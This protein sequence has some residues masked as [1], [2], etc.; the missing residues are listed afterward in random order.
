MKTYELTFYGWSGTWS[1]DI[2][3]K[4][5]NEAIDKAIPF[6]DNGA[7]KYDLKTIRVWNSSLR[8]WQKLDYKIGY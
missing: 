7:T 5:E 1:I 4:N 3:A 8:S 6:A 2:K